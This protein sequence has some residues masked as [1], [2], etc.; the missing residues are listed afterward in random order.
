MADLSLLHDPRSEAGPWRCV[1][2]GSSRLR[3]DQRLLF[4]EDPFDLGR[5]IPALPDFIDFQ[6][7]CLELSASE[8]LDG[9][10]NVVSEANWFVDR[11]LS[12]GTTPDEVLSCDLQSKLRQSQA[13]IHERRVERLPGGTGLAVSNEPSNWGSYL[14]RILPKIL[15]FKDMGLERVLAYSAN[16]QHL[17]LFDL[18]GLPRDRVIAHDPVRDYLCAGSLFVSE[19]TT[20][21]YL[22]PG[23][24]AALKRLG[25]RYRGTSRRRLYVSRSA[26]M[27]ARSGRTCVNEKALEARLQALGVEILYPDQLSVREQIAVFASASLIVGCSG[28][29]MFNCVFAPSDAIVIEIESS[30]TWS[31]A[32]TSLFS[33]L[34]LR[35]GF[36]WG[37]PEDDGGTSPHRPFT[38]DLDAV[39]RRVEDFV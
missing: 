21:L 5:R 30:P 15:H 7:F 8:T 9:L 11:V 28:A 6:S 27:A 29:G 17:E 23:A 25:D 1:Q 31:Y 20:A 3:S 24:R 16:R 18:I 36:V 33:S 2:S 10:R 26:G 19:P 34:G 14:C 39:C 38:V 22:E 32:H 37:L 12:P 35:H 13:A 4:D